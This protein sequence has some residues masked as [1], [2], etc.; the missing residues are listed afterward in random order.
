M[1]GPAA[2][3]IA[4]AAMSAVSQMQQAQAARSQTKY[5]AAVAANNATAARQQAAFQEAREREQFDRTLATQRVRFGK[6]GVTAEGTALDV[7]ADRAVSGELEALKIRR[8][9]LLQS[10]SY[11]NQATLDNM[12]GSAALASG[13]LNAGSSLLM[14]AGRSGGSTGS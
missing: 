6:G 12:R 5:S 11:S 2:I 3:M 1:C 10:Q 7:N 8:S 13:M 9:G 4:G 14:A